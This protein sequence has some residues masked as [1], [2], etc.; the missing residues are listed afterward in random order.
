MSEFLF[1]KFKDSYTKLWN[2]MI[3]K[4]Q[5]YPQVAYIANKIYSYR[6]IY[7]KVDL[8]IPFSIIGCIHYRE[9]NFNFNTHLHNG[10]PL[11][12]RT[13]REP[14][15][16]PLIGN[17][18]FRWEESARDALLMKSK[19]F[20]KDNIWTIER[21]LFFLEAYNGFGY[22]LYKRI[23]SP[24]LWSGSNHYVSGKYRSDGVY[25][26]DL[27]DRQIGCACILKYGIDH[28][29]WIL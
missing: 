13:I 26:P 22:R 28:N 21:C 16:R 9:S 19:L 23:N 8:P 17:P 27:V 11:T 4:P 3:I 10:D 14:K 1:N 6:E 7:Q 2:S 12:N 25:S 20:P 29:L 18:P 5:V 24:Y 15:N